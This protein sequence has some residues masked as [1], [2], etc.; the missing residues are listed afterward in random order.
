VFESNNIFT[1]HFPFFI[2]CFW[3]HFSLWKHAISFKYWKKI[4]LSFLKM[5]CTQVRVMTNVGWV[6]KIK[7]LSRRGLR[8]FSSMLNISLTKARMILNFEKTFFNSY[9]SIVWSLKQIKEK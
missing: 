4:V 9:T 6:Y 3:A 2:F 8:L 1:T 5:S 7:C